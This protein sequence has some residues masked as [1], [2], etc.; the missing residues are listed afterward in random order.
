[1]SVRF[2]QELDVKLFPGFRFQ[3]GS[4]IV[5]RLAQDRLQIESIVPKDRWKLQGPK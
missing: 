1:M 2:A 4:E 3:E 5:D